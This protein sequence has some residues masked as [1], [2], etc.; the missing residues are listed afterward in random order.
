MASSDNP[1]TPKTSLPPKESP[2]ESPKESPKKTAKRTAPGATRRKIYHFVKECI[3]AGESPSIRDVQ[4]EM[5]FS[6]VQSARQHLEAL[7]AEGLLDK[8][9][10]RA[11]GFRLPGL[12][13]SAAPTRFVPLLGRVAAGA[14]TTAIEDPEGYLAVQS[15]LPQNELFALKVRG[16][17][18]TGLGIL[19][20]DIVIVKRQASAENGE[21]VVA[22]IGDEATVKTLRKTSKGI[23]FDPANPA[24]QPIHPGIEDVSILGKVVEVRR[25]LD[26]I[27]LH[28]DPSLDS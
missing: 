28:Q 11:R 27:Q 18:M 6:A 17:S 22:L 2:Q 19:P 12:H 16:E 3:L 14:P 15:R 5:G 7:V 10:G 1:K 21:I 9:A 13:G 23:Q 4:K 8:E 20:D 26:G 25:Y 24:F